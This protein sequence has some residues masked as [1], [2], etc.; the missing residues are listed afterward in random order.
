MANLIFSLSLLSALLI[1]V[2]ALA[3]ISMKDFQFWPP[4][5]KSS[6]QYHV[7]WWSF[8]AV[9]A[10]I[11]ILSIID[12]NGLVV[13]N[14]PTRLYV[15]ILLAVLGFSLAF[16]ITFYLG[17]RNAHG[18]TEGLKT[19]GW[20]AWSRNPVYLVSFFGFIGWALAINSAYIYVLFAFLI[21]FYVIAPFLE[22]PW[23]EKRYGKAYLEYKSKVPRFFGIHKVRT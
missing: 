18:E 7:F 9:I 4:P 23:L 13:F 2:L 1:F 15:G 12:F 22:E 3:S 10:G 5:S 11:V 16:Y 14:H 19:T 17:W 8:R 21:A 6:W 20:Y